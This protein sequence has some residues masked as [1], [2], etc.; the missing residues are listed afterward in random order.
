[1]G[2]KYYEISYSDVAFDHK[3]AGKEVG[4][5]K[6]SIYKKEMTVDYMAK[7]IGEKGHSFSPAVFSNGTK[8]ENFQYQQLIGLDFDHGAT[9]A[10]IKAKADKYRIP[11]LFAYKTFSWTE[12]EERFRVIFALSRTIEDSFTVPLLIGDK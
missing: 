2:K 7:F 9:F 8:K 11:I 5:I 4:M 12:T 1:M 10:E 6:K 3:P